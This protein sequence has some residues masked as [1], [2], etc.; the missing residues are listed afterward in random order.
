MREREVENRVRSR[1]KEKTT[2]L[3]NLKIDPRD[4]RRWFCADHS[5]FPIGL[6]TSIEV[7]VAAANETDEE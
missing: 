7:V 5:V 3:L 4:T 6:Y 1:L 2:I